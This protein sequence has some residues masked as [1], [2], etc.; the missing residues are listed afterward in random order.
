MPTKLCNQVLELDVDHQGI[1]RTKSIA[2]SFVWWPNNDNDIELCM[3]FCEGY[4]LQQ[5]NPTPIKSHPWGCSP[6]FF[7]DR[8]GDQV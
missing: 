8:K 1:V 3:K 6:S 7:I 5:K 2:H 4:A